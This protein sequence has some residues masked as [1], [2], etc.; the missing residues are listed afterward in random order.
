MDSWNGIHDK[1][2]IN[3]PCT[4]LG[5][6]LHVLHRKWLYVC[7]ISAISKLCTDNANENTILSL[8]RGDIT[9]GP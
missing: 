5:K 9:V 7:F 8:I 4:N 3:W 6:F 2:H 1:E